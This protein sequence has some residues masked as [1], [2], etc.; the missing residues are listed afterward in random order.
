MQ[1]LTSTLLLLVA[2]LPAS[3]AAQAPQSAPIGDI[4]YDVT[5][6]RTTAAARQMRV[7]T[8]FDVTNAQPVLLSLPTWT[9]GAYEVTNFARFVSGFSATQNGAAL[10]W[11]KLDY[12][13]WRIVPSGRGRVELEFMFAATELDNA[14]SYALADFLMFNGTNVFLYPEG[15]GFDFASRVTLRTDPAWKIATGMEHTGGTGAVREYSAPNYH[16]LVDMPVFMG[17][18]EVD[19][20]QA[21]G[22]WSRL[23]SYPVGSLS[24]AARATW[25]QQVARYLPELVE[26]FGARPFQHHTTLLLIDPEFG[27]GSALEHQNSHV[28]I[29]H[30]GMLPLMVF[31]SITAHEMAHIWNVKRLR[32]ADMFPYDYDEAQPTTLLW[33]SEGITDYYADL[34]LVRANVMSTQ[35]FYETTQQKMENVAQTPAVA[36]EDASLETWIQPTDGTAYIYYDKGSI[37]GLLLDIMI[38]DAS[39][40]RSSLDHVMRELYDATWE[41]GRGFTREDWWAT[42]SRAAGGRSFEEFERRYI[43]GRDPFPYAEVLPLAGLVLDEDTSRVARMGVGMNSGDDGF[44]IVSVVPG[45]SFDQAG[46]Q[47][48]DTILAIDDLPGGGPGDVG[49]R[50]RERFNNRPSGSTMTLR[51]RRDGRELRLTAPIVFADAYTRTLREL[52]NPSAKA[53]RIRNAILRGE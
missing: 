17:A 8:S 7:R 10:D 50:F 51:V 40:N 44:E 16:D 22:V 26:A 2:A 20:A 43:D 25:H 37:A 13:T 1:K 42:V 46:V 18:L 36:L 30:P 53:L 4:R 41:R 5:F 38:R 6:D 33:V 45:G 27:G 9:P 23:A 47:V 14:K 19:S 31:P 21:S 32:P 29:Y 12:D 11:D 3:V 24:G 39:D 28:G 48:G 15:R 52:P 49:V 35:E 34:A